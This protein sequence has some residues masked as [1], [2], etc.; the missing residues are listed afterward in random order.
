V[1][2]AQ[3][4]RRW[5]RRTP[6]AAVAPVLLQYVMQYFDLESPAV[7]GQ[8][9]ADLGRCG[10]LGGTRTPNLL[11]RRGGRRTGPARWPGALRCCLRRP[12]GRAAPPRGGSGLRRPCPSSL[13]SRRRHAN[14]TR[15][16]CCSGRSSTSWRRGTVRHCATCRVPPTDRR[17]TSVRPRCIVSSRLV[18]S[19]S[20]P[21][22]ARRVLL[23]LDGVV[24]RRPCRSA[25]GGRARVGR[26]A[27]SGSRS[28]GGSGVLMGCVADPTGAGLRAGPASSPRRAGN[29]HDTDLL[30]R[31]RQPGDPCHAQR[32]TVTQADL[33]TKDHASGAGRS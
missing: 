17:T 28:E 10:A 15:P 12:I 23:R 5:V 30:G 27:R 20:G 3:T 6:S 14:R 31:L 1:R 33:C 22:R 16:R 4:A 25:R 2:P 19:R 7:A 26:S 13:T 24:T 8:P 29:P 21:G 32:S 11:I 18:V 9:A